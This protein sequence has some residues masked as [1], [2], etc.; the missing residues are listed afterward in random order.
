MRNEAL[1]ECLRRCE[2]IAVF[3]SA[4]KNGRFVEALGCGSI[5][6]RIV[7]CRFRI[8]FKVAVRTMPSAPGSVTHYVLDDLIPIITHEIVYGIGGVSKNISTG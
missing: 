3:A 6:L 7:D 5:V 8:K 4:H 1:K 2:K